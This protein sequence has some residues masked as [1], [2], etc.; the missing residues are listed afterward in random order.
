MQISPLIACISFALALASGTY[1][2]YSRMFADWQSESAPYGW[3][4][5]WVRIV[6]WLIT[7]CGSLIGAV[8]VY[9]FIITATDKIYIGGLAA[10]G[11]LYI[12]YFISTRRAMKQYMKVVQ[13]EAAETHEL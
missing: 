10:A 2:Q 5:P 12:R 3:R 13:S 9:E 4:N 6:L 7:T 8:Y 11:I 1:D